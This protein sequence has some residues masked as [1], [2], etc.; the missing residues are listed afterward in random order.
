[1]HERTHLIKKLHKK[2]SGVETQRTVWVHAD[3]LDS[4]QTR[5]A[6]SA[7]IVMGLYSQVTY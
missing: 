1:M 6:D 7:A 2:A 4:G 3:V 5:H